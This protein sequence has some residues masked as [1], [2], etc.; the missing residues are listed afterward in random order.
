VRWLLRYRTRGFSSL[1]RHKDAYSGAQYGTCTQHANAVSSKHCA[2]VEC[3]ARHF[4][5]VEMEVVTVVRAVAFIDV[6]LW[7]LNESSC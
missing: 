4:S 7:C 5:H 2:K 3:I 1:T 6:W